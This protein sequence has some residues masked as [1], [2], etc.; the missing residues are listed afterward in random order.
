MSTA[1]STLEWTGFNLYRLVGKRRDFIGHVSKVAVGTEWE[2]WTRDTYR[3]TCAT[4]QLAQDRLEAYA[5][6]KP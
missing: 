3:T 4:R 6:G 1:V 5:K 2:V